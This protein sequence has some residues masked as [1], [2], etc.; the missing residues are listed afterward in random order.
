MY[1]VALGVWWRLVQLGLSAPG[2]NKYPDNIKATSHP[3]PP[4]PA[5]PAALATLRLEAGI[6]GGED[7]ASTEPHTH[8][9]HEARCSS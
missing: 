7:P 9:Q 8:L 2:L 4:E 3:Q 5:A 1:R 6:D